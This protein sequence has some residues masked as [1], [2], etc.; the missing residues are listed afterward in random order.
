MFAGKKLEDGT[1]WLQT[2]PSIQIEVNTAVS[3]PRGNPL[4]IFSK[5]LTQN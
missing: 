1:N 4:G 5:A 3:G 2:G